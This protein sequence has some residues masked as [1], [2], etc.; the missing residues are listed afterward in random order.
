MKRWN[1]RRG[2]TLVE[3]LVVAAILLILVVTF[4]PLLERYI[5]RRNRRGSICISNVRQLATAVQMY[6]QDNQSRYPG[7]NWSDAILTYVGSQKIFFCDA[8]KR[9]S[10]MQPISY[11]Y[12]GLLVRVDGTGCNEAQITAPTEVGAICD[13]TPTRLFADGGSL[14]GGGAMVTAEDNLV[15]TPM[16]RHT[17]VVVGFCDGHAKYYPGKKPDFKDINNPV[18]RAFYQVAGY[19][20]ITNYGGGQ[21]ALSANPK[22]GKK[23]ITLGGDFAG[24]AQA[25]AAADV[26]AQLGGKWFTRNF[27]GSADARS[28]AKAKAGGEYCW[29][30]ADG[31]PVKTGEVEIARDALVFI[32]SKNTKLTAVTQCRITDTQA[33]AMSTA[34]IGSLFVQ[35]NGFI[36][37]TNPQ[38]ATIAR[39]AYTYNSANG[40]YQYFK[41][42]VG[43]TI[44]F[45][46]YKGTL[47]ADDL[48]MVEKVAG[49]PYGIGYCSSAVADPDKVIIIDI[50]P[51]QGGAPLHFPN[52]NPKFAS[53]MPGST[54]GTTYPFVRPIKV[55]FGTGKQAREFARIFRDQSFL[56]GPLF[57][58]NYFRPLG[59]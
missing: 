26:W 57:V 17:G 36:D 45:K 53:T 27:T 4:Y 44:P 23:T 18:S 50:I 34:A 46:G 11:G 16:P 29:V 19:G 13:A 30:I 8:D 42:C 28:K 37:P 52:P 31:T 14:I 6:N 47:V 32:V 48:E 1:A 54:A 33:Y 39:V 10:G 59:Q 22:I 56:Q 40:N 58:T 20:M 5:D 51:A 43:I 41:R 9:I 55:E 7:K 15:G 2:F 24:A 49:D 38:N 35:N 25:L 3:L 12:S 21:R